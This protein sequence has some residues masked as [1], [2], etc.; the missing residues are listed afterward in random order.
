MERSRAGRKI[1]VYPSTEIGKER[2]QCLAPL[3][4]TAHA[5]RVP[6][7][8]VARVSGISAQC[9]VIN[10]HNSG[11]C[12]LADWWGGCPRCPR[13]RPCAVQ[14]RF[15]PVRTKLKGGGGL[16]VF[17]R[18]IH[19]IARA[20]G[21]PESA[22]KMGRL[23][24]K[25]EEKQAGAGEFARVWCLLWPPCPLISAAVGRS[26]QYQSAGRSIPGGLIAPV[27]EGC[28]P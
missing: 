6:T 11:R 28:P 23:S 4:S 12:L 15:T 1:L 19:L 26:A 16:G 24:D 7:S 9:V 10:R 21:V 25:T 18:K 3:I 17:R 8:S 27:G 2:V 20:R 13:R 14:R 22:L 5:G